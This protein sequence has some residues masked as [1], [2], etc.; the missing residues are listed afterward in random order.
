MTNDV[1]AQATGCISV[2]EK[3]EKGATER[4]RKWED[5]PSGGSLQCGAEGE[6]YIDIVFYSDNWYQCIKSFTKGNGVVPTNTIYFKNIT[7][8]QR[9]ATNIFLAHEAY[10]HNLVVDKVN[11]VENGEVL[12]RADK[13]G[14]VGNK[15]VFND[16]TV[17]GVITNEG[18]DYTI[19]IDN[20][21]IYFITANETFHLGLDA[22][23]KPDWLSNKPYIYTSTFYTGNLI[24]SI[25][26]V[27]L[28][29]TDKKTYYTDVNL[30][31]KASGTYYSDENR[32]DLLIRSSEGIYCVYGASFAQVKLYRKCSFSNG[33]K[34]ELGFIATGYNFYLND[35]SN[36]FI[37]N[38]SKVY[39]APS[40]ITKDG[41]TSYATIKEVM[42]NGTPRNIDRSNVDVS[43][44][45]GSYIYPLVSNGNT[46]A[47][48]ST[49][50]TIAQVVTETKFS[51]QNLSV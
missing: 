36:T 15:C 7:D 25:T 35:T 50:S 29:T 43:L 31:K 28:Y 49:C 11:I 6:Q 40:Q 44:V 4:P 16:A 18:A 45:S 9:L 2:V 39:F 41:I 10:I 12:L 32:G 27:T 47:V 24:S 26:S 3:G 51:V 46:E 21:V 19:K 5:I 42:V 13:E 33:I 1:L 20:G 22:N 14:V 23:G 8:Y 17:S 30:T 38:S 34:T 48:F 37:K